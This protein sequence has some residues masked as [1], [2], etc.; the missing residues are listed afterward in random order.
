MYQIKIR[1]SD[2]SE[3]V[4][5]M[6]PKCAYTIDAL[7]ETAEDL[8]HVYDYVAIFDNSNELIKEITNEG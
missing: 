8:L 6:F 2:T 1:R 4:V 7:L 3:W 5:P